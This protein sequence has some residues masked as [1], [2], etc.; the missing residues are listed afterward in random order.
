M[1]DARVAGS[2]LPWLRFPAGGA[3]DIVEACDLIGADVAGGDVAEP[4]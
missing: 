3:Q 2:V 1:I 4:Q